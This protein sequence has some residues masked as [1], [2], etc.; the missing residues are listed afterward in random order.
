VGFSDD[1]GGGEKRRRRY[2]KTKNGE[3]IGVFLDENFTFSFFSI[4]SVARWLSLALSRVL[5][6][7]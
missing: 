6:S 4:F 3:K 2:L 1:A 5:G 7:D